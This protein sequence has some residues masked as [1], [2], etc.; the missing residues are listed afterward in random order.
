MYNRIVQV[1]ACWQLFSMLQLRQV[2]APNIVHMSASIWQ[3]ARLIP[4]Y[5]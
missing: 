3:L 4:V 1:L 2:K 5:M